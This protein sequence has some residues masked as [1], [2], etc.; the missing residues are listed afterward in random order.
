MNSN[1]QRRIIKGAVAAVLAV[2]A[3]AAVAHHS[4]ALYDMEKTLTFTGVVTRVN[5]DAN[6]LQIFFAPMNAERKNVERDGEGKPVV[7]A[8]EMT[9][10]AQAAS[11][12]ISV[13][14][15][16]PGT[17]FSVGLHPL[18]SGEH[19]GARVNPGSIYKCPD[20]KPPAAGKGCDTVDGSQTI[21]GGQLPIGTAPGQQP[22]AKK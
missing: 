15:F 12:G 21:G 6:H 13:S 20:K 18:R 7:W 5:P 19:A 8:V 4:F 9:G 10:S 11:D 2:G 22:P 14:S 1:T 16:P 3:A 17:I